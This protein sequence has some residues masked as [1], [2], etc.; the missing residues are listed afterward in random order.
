M[1]FEFTEQ[2]KLQMAVSKVF[3]WVGLEYMDS[4]GKETMIN[5]AYKRIQKQVAKGDL[6]ALR[7]FDGETQ[8]R[9]AVEL[10]ADLVSEEIRYMLFTELMRFQ[11]LTRSQVPEYYNTQGNARIA[12]ML[13][14]Y[15]VKQIDV[16]RQE[17]IN[18]A[19][20]EAKKGN[21]KKSALAA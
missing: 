7:I 11:P 16:M 17:G 12:Y 3:K 2:G 20:S 21:A 8:A 19:I 9:V 13:K 4:V 1:L 6:S 15:L 14:T 18:E 5:G 10:G